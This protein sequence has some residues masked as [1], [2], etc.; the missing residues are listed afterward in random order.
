MKVTQRKAV[1]VLIAP[2][3]EAL[4]SRLMLLPGSEAVLYQHNSPI[5]K[6]FRCGDVLGLGKLQLGQDTLGKSQQHP[7]P[8]RQ[9]VP[10]AGEVQRHGERGKGEVETFSKNKRQP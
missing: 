1:N 2:G 5:S 8:E 9:L 7:L 4:C 3:W 6:M 10:G